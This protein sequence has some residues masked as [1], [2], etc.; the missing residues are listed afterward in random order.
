MKVGQVCIYIKSNLKLIVEITEVTL[1]E[2]V[3]IK[4][5]KRIAGDFAPST[6]NHYPASLKY[7][8]KV[9]LLYKEKHVKK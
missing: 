4:V 6:P 5:L 8:T 7:L 3:W 2:Y 9:K 1:E